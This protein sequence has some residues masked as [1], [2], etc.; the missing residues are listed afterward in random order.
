[1]ELY[2]VPVVCVRRPYRAGPIAET[3]STSFIDPVR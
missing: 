3:G 1:L 2:R